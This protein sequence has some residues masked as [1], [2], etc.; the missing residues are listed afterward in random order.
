LEIRQ[1]AQWSTKTDQ[2]E[3][4]TLVQNNF[5]Y[6]ELTMEELKLLQ[7]LQQQTAT[8]DTQFFQTTPQRQLKELN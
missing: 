2:K 5:N 6:T 1:P 3:K 7:K 4:L 8:E